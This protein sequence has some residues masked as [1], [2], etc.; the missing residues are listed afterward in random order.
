MSKKV[1]EELKDIKPKTRK[2]TK[3]MLQLE[4][5]KKAKRKKILITLLVLVIL[6]GAFVAYWMFFGRYTNSGL[7]GKW[8]ASSCVVDGTT[9]D[10]ESMYEEFSVKLKAK[11]NCTITSGESK[12]NGKWVPT[13][14]GFKFVGE[15]AEVNGNAIEFVKKGKNKIQFEDSGIKYTFVRKTTK[16]K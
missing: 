9:I 6:A 8:T 13:E 16:D 7:I 5:R 3:A 12:V 2:Y 15:D 10:I 4:A 11:G 14:K 1:P